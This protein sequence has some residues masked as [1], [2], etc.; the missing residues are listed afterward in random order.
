VEFS[1]Q[2]TNSVCDGNAN[3]LVIKRAGG[4]APPPAR[5]RQVK[6][7]FPNTQSV[8]IKEFR[9]DTHVNAQEDVAMDFNRRLIM[10]APVWVR[11]YGSNPNAA[12]PASDYQ[13][14]FETDSI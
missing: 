8:N 3:E 14:I 12:A 7:P 6:L 11:R 10:A 4:V 2:Q 13:Q 5:N 9:N 1:I